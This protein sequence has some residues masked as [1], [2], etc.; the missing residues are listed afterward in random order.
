MVNGLS[1][2]MATRNEAE[3]IS[4]VIRNL[5]LVLNKLPI[6]SELIVADFSED[7]TLSVAMEA[8]RQ[9][10]VSVKP[11]KIKQRGRGYAVRQGIEIAK[12]DLIC[13]ID[14]D[15]NHDPKYIPRLLG[16]Y[17]SNC[18]VSPTRF[19]P[20]G[21]SEEHTFSHYFGNRLMVI[22]LNLLFGSN[23][24]DITNGYYLMSRRVWN[25]LSPESN[26]WSLDVQIIIRALKRGI[27][28]I[29]IPYYEPKRQGGKASLTLSTALWRIGGRMLLEFITQ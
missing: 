13:L 27:E 25:Y 6:K 14:G 16:A 29:E 26:N 1:L 17:K 2:V 20:L 3:S 22:S 23:V 7:A 11:F 8:G 15:G 5:G 4:E 24:S 18:I 21:W 10:S 28:I 19:P 12:F 9:F